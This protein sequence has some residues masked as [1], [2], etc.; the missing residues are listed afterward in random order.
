MNRIDNSG[1]GIA[2]LGRDEDKYMA[3]VAAGEMVVPPVIT[4]ET[5]ARLFQEMQ[6]VGLD[7]S[8]Y[9]VGAGMSINPITGLPEFGFFKKIIKEAGPIIGAVVG[10]AVGGP[11]GASAGAALGTKTSAMDDEDMGRNAALAF[12]LSGGLGPL[13]TGPAGTSPAGNA[14]SGIGSLFGGGTGTAS[15]TPGSSSGG[16]FFSNIGSSISNFF[17]GGTGGGAGDSQYTVQSG[18]TLSQIALDNGTTTDALAQANGITNPDRILIGQN[19]TIPGG[20]SSSGLGGL[21]GNIGSSLGNIFGGGTGGSAAQS[22]SNPLANLLGSAT[23]AQAQGG[24]GILDTILKGIVAKRLLDQESPNPADIVPLGINAFG[25]TPEMT[26]ALKNKDYSIGNLRPALIEGQNYANLTPEG[27]VSDAVNSIRTAGNAAGLPT[28]TGSGEPAPLPP[29]ILPPP[30]MQLN[31]PAIPPPEGLNLNF[32]APNAPNYTPLP[33]LTGMIPNI[34]GTAGYRTFEMGGMIPN[35]EMG[36][37][38]GLESGMMVNPNRMDNN[39]PGDITPAFLEP[40][41]FVMTRPATQVLGARNLYKL[42][43][44]AE[45]MT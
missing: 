16:G 43:K 21:F 32:T 18:D 40:G 38:L 10:G 4:A 29:S 17:G 14:A 12:G 20:S 22:N 23:G 9:T 39:G 24:G 3:H 35:Y 13:G 45:Q 28:L 11:I 36:G 44:Q 31:A 25:Y 33:D 1:A 37:I 19:L 27:A 42:M 5:R 6:Q 30:P 8:E 26:E 34:G 7:P 41:E 15:T 2:R